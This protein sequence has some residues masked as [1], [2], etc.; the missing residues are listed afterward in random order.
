MNSGWLGDVAGH[1]TSVTRRFDAAYGTEEG[2]VGGV[3]IALESVWRGLWMGDQNLR[4][5][6]GRCPQNYLGTAGLRHI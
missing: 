2:G 1:V 4:E 3:V 6:A 5:Y